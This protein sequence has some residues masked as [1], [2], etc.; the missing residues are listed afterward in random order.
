MTNPRMA[1]EAAAAKVATEWAHVEAKW[2][3]GD[4]FPRALADA[5]D[6]LR[7]AVLAVQPPPGGV[8]VIITDIRPPEPEVRYVPRKGRP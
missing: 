2:D 3:Q 7:D 5:L 1:L 6:A 4:P 8:P